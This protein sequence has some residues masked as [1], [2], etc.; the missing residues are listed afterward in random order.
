MRGALAKAN[1]GVARATQNAAKLRER[2]DLEYIPIESPSPLILTQKDFAQE[3]W[4]IY[5]IR[6]QGPFLIMVPSALR[7]ERIYT[8]K[9]ERNSPSPIL[10]IPYDPK[11][12]LV[13]AG[14]S[15][16]QLVF[17][18]GANRMTGIL[19][20]YQERGIISAGATVTCSGAT[21][22]GAPTG[23]GDIEGE[24]FVAAAADAGP[25][26]GPP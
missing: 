1:L 10:I 26:G 22:P 15:V 12:D 17:L 19:Q 9:D 18:L 16:L 20:F 4:R 11:F 14:M 7:Q 3:T 13:Q 8:I 25:G 2:I 21:T 5:G 23:F 6:T 24:G